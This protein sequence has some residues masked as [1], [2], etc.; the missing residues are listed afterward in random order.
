MALAVVR[1][2]ARKT[3]DT[4]EIDRLPETAL[5]CGSLQAVQGRNRVFQSGNDWK[6]KGVSHAND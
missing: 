4:D 1:D 6:I 2:K 5:V 3:W